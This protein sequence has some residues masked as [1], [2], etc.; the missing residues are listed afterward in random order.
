VHLTVTAAAGL[1]A[2]HQPSQKGSGQ[3]AA[4]AGSINAQSTNKHELNNCVVNVAPVGYKLQPHLIC[5][6]PLRDPAEQCTFCT[7]ACTA[8]ALVQPVGLSAAPAV[9]PVSHMFI[10]PAP[11]GPVLYYVLASTSISQ[12]LV[13]FN[14]AVQCSLSS[15]CSLEAAHL[16][17]QPFQTKT[18]AA[19]NQ[20]EM[21][22]S[23]CSF[24]FTGLI[25]AACSH[26]GICIRV[27]A[28]LRDHTAT[29]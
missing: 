20:H 21:H 15:G 2:S 22:L 24:H 28:L 14:P 26:T 5:I 29:G 19:I 8:V 13:Q 12:N 17:L 7:F 16:L 9:Q 4:A 10:G 25:T 1:S 27:N 11:C 3:A 6:N 18:V 23:H